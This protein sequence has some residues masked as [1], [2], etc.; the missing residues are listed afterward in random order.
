MA[1]LEWKPKMSVGVDALDTDNKKFIGIINRLRD[2][3]DAGDER[4]EV[5]KVL[6]ELQHYFEYHFATEEKLLRITKYPE[7]K[8]H[9]GLHA[10]LMG[11]LGRFREDFNFAPDTFMTLDLYDFLSDY[12]MRHILRADM[13]FKPHLEERMRGASGG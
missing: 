2:I 1:F 4:A 7:Y 3:M 9:A 6:D 10:E 5:R 8:E 12:L 13:A 11:Q